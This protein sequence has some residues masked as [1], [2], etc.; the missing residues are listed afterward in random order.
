MTIPGVWVGVRGG[1]GGGYGVKGTIAETTQ[2]RLYKNANLKAKHYALDNFK[3][4][5]AHCYCASLQRTQ[6]HLPRHASSARAKY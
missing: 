1:G 4:V 5:R 3:D 6:I 2:N